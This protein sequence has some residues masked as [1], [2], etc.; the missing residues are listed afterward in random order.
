ML[1]L[2]V[3]EKVVEADLAT[4]RLY[5]P[6]CDGPLARWG[7]ARERQIRTRAGERTLRPRRAHC[8]RCGQTHVLLPAWSV[9]RRR[10]S[11]EL[12]GAAL[13]AKAQGHG[14]RTIAVELGRPASTVRGWLR[15][16]ARRATRVASAARLWTHALDA[17]QERAV[18]TGSALSDA[19]EAL[20]VATREARLRLGIRAGPWELAVALS[21]GLL[22][23]DPSRPPGY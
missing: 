11:T 3:S 16:F 13:L 19:V 8:P 17:S 21:G 18:E 20:G 5:C 6:C 2:V 10:D 9:P 15:A 22:V 4:G 12:I 7:Y 23:G 1:S 14:H